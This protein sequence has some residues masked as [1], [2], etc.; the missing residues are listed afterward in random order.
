MSHPHLITTL[1]D[2]HGLGSCKANRLSMGPSLRLTKDE[3]GS[4][5]G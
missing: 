5:G 2:G 3:G 1:V 4:V